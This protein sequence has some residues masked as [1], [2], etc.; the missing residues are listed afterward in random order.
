M[1]QLMQDKLCQFKYHQSAEFCF[2]LSEKESS[3][4]KNHILAD[5]SSYFSI[6]ESVSVLPSIIFTLFAGSWC[7]RLKNGRR[8][9]LM[10]TLW[11]QSLETLFLLLNTIFYDWD[12]KY[13]LLS[14][15]PTALTGNGL[16]MACCSYIVATTDDKSRPVK[17]LA[18]EVANCVGM[19]LGFLVGPGIMVTKSLLFANA[20][21]RNF[22]DV[23]LACIFMLGVSIVWAYF[24]VRSEDCKPVPVPEV[25]QN[26]IKD[27]DCSQGTTAT[28]SSSV[29]LPDKKSCFARCTSGITSLFA[30]QDLRDIRETLTK[31]RP[32][33]GR[34]YMW[35]MIAVQVA[36]MLPLLGAIYVVFPY[37]EQAYEWNNQKY[38]F[39][40][41]LEMAVRPIAVA[42]YTWLVV[43]R[44]KLSELEITIVGIVSSIMGLIAIG[45]ITNEYGFYVESFAASLTG[46]AVPGSRSFLSRIIPANEITK[47]FC[48]LQIIDTVLPFA[49]SAFMSGIFKATISFYP[50]LMYQCCAIPLILALV[51]VTRIDVIRLRTKSEL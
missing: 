10:A 15:I 7:D 32:D 1:Q 34:R 47:V 3:T 6:K 50:S 8:Y 21:L 12:F 22:A 26:V 51:A 45:S 14:G 13:I 48:M 49:G 9:V 46:T 16:H 5:M 11:G 27:D 24:R 28:S 41:A 2:S 43:K 30:I 29:Q 20:G 44:F 37:M 23:F 4:M 17:F 18:F 42:L 35:T 25:N 33:N 38:G 31:A 39:M 19:V 40:M 36:I